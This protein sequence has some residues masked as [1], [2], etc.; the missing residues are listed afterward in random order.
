LQDFKEEFQ[1]QALLS[2][3]LE[4]QDSKSKTKQVLIYKCYEPINTVY[5]KEYM[6]YIMSK[7]AK[8]QDK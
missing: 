1:A 4:G 5:L 6:L 8:K 7:K 3:G 2:G